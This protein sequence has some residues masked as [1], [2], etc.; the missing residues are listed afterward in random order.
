VNA[1]GRMLLTLLTIP[2]FTA[3]SER[4]FSAMRRI[5]T[6]LRSTMKNERL[7]SI[8]ILH[9]HRS[10]CVSIEG[11][12]DEFAGAANRRLAFVFNDENCLKTAVKIDE[13]RPDAL[14]KTMP[15]VFDNYQENHL[16]VVVYFL[17]LS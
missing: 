17:N 10:K 8:S 4:S 3:A 16:P 7:S 5:K 9:I 6:Y 14:K 11:I 2:V 15:L 1:I 12:I 13:Q